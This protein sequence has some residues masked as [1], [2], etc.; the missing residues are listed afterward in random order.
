[1]KYAITPM[2]CKTLL[3]YLEDGA[4]LRTI[5]RYGK[6]L[7]ELHLSSGEYIYV[8]R[9]NISALI[10]AGTLRSI[11]FSGNEFEY[12]LPIEKVE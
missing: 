6:R 9:S 12:Y 7:N 4:K 8:Q 2:N 1:M 10:K 5:W 11:L 3:V